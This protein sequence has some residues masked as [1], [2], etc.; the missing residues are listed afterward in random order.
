AL[1]EPQ[2]KGVING[3]NHLYEDA[4]SLVDEWVERYG[5]RYS[6][7]LDDLGYYVS[8]WEGR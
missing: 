2:L 4:F 7:E 8:G 1:S 5:G 3:L 6:I